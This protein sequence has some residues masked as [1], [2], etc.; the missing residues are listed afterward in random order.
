MRPEKLKVGVIMYQT[1]NSKGQELVA[2]R[3]TAEFRRKGDTAYL[4]TSRFH[5]GRPV[6]SSRDLN[7]AGWLM[8]QE[9]R[10]GLPVIR[11]ASYKADWPP[12]RIQFKNFVSVL[13]RLVTE[14]DLDVLVSHSTLWNG[15]EAVARFVA[16]ENRVGRESGAKKPLVYC[17]MS[18]YQPPAPERYGLR[19]RVYRELW[20]EDHF[21][22]IIME[23]DFLLVTTPLAEAAMVK[24]GARPEQCFMFPGGIEVPP[25]RTGEEIA[26]FRR[27]YRLPN[28]K[29]VTYLGTVEERKNPM[30]LAKVA[31][32]LSERED[33]HF[34][35]GGRLD[36]EY[37]VE[38]ERIGKEIQNLTVLGEISEGDKAS[39]VRTS[40]LNI[41]LS[42]LEALGMV[43]LEFMSA[44]IPV[45]TSGTGGQAWV[46]RD[47]ETGVCLNG[48]DDLD[49]AAAAVARL[50]D[51]QELRNRM[52]SKAKKFATQYTMQ[53]LV[54]ELRERIRER[55][56]VRS[57]S[58]GIDV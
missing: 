35:I 1:S 6:I 36:N 28:A 26:E 50:A 10:I 41:T 3:M 32:R 24:M 9:K 7:Q 42:R 40:Y 51:D 23:A 2:Q 58:A 55:L 22:R 5:D 20:N 47:G 39:L 48:P 54:G 14:F 34:V 21:R 31:E 19:E 11:V 4:I 30:S 52:G 46:V 8:R 17:H 33:I 56:T 13:D 16:W 45:V 38:V 53:S 43:Q 37:G 25:Q 29:L 57:M 15:P 12:R 44:G 18:H 27:R 49:G